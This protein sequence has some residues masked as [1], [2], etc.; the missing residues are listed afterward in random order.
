MKYY[1]NTITGA[2]S[3]T[4]PIDF[5]VKGLWQTYDDFAPSSTKTG[6]LGT[7]STGKPTNG[8]SSW[9]DTFGAVVSSL[10]A[11]LPA[12]LG[13]FGIGSKTPTTQTQV[14]TAAGSAGSASASGS[15]SAGAGSNNGGSFNWTTLLLPVVGIVVIVLLITK[16]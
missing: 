8:K 15:G 3:Y 9:G 16:K 4:I 12:V 5:N 10:T 11:S 1:K 2:I 6:V 7:S 13:A 14:T